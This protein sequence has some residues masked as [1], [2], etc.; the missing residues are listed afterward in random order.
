MGT[1]R[2]VYHFY[3]CNDYCDNIANKVHFECFKY[4]VSV[5][6]KIVIVFACDDNLDY[7]LKD[8]IVSKI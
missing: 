4:Y 5:F 3:L 1:K 2:L 8:E 6:D 7:E